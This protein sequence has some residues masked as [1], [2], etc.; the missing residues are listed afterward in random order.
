MEGLVWIDGE[1]VPAGEAAV[2]VFDHGLLY[3]DGVF[4]GIRAYRGRVFRLEQHLRRFQRSALSIQLTIP[5]T[6]D[7]LTEFICETLRQN[8]LDD[9]YIRLVAT[10][11]IGDLGLDPRKCERPTVFI[12]AGEIALHPQEDSEKGLRLVT[13]ATRR[14]SPT[15]VD[16]SVK[17]LNYLNNILAKIEVINAGAEEGLLL[18]QAG[19]VAEATGENIFMVRDGALI[20]PP[21]HAGILEGITRAAVMELAQGMELPV[22]EQVFSRYELFSAEECFLTGTAAEII[23]VIQIDGRWIGEG[24]PGPITRRLHDAFHALTEVDGVPIH[25]ESSVVS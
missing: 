24:R 12:I 11:G 8:H 1:L 2:S 7:Q 19:Y 15:A 25:E 23:P 22:R 16:P 20:T 6:N 4:E 10:R 13:V 3:G 18:N 5:Y 17:S 21:V 14:N 9:A